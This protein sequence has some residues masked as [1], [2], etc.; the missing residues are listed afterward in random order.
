MIG[1]IVSIWSSCNNA[2]YWK[3]AMVK[4]TA[5]YLRVKLVGFM[6]LQVT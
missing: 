3:C 2:S 4:I 1:F 6:K 5:Q